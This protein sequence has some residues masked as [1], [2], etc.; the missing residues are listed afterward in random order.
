MTNIAPLEK[1]FPPFLKSPWGS[2]WNKLNYALSCIW[3]VELVHEARTFQHDV[4]P[5]RLSLV[6]DL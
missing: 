1:E 3:T 5:N 2:D 4:G 6:F